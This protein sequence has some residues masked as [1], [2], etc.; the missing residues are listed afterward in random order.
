MILKKNLITQNFQLAPKSLS[1]NGPQI[2]SNATDTD[3]IQRR[4]DT[5]IDL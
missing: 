1:R 5:F 3:F 2:H 4:K